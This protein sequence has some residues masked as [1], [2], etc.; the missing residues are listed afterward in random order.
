MRPTRRLNTSSWHR[1][2]LAEHRKSAAPTKMSSAAGVL[3]P[4]ASRL[5]L[6][7]PAGSKRLDSTGLDNI[8][9]KCLQTHF[10]KMT[11]FRLTHIESSTCRYNIQKR[12]SKNKND[13]YHEEND[14][15][16]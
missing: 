2:R 7:R 3:R 12:N 13:S 6:M 14:S 16:S 5:F 1:R 15:E 8:V 9:T 11:S 10:M 4:A